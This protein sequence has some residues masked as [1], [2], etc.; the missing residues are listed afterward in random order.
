MET[1][2]RWLIAMDGM[3][4]SGAVIEKTAALSAKE[5]QNPDISLLLI[6]PSEEHTGQ[7][8]ASAELAKMLV[9]EY[10]SPTMRPDTLIKTGSGADLIA[11]TAQNLKC[12]KII[13]GNE[14]SG[15]VQHSLNMKIKEPQKKHNYQDVVALS[16]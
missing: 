11:E 6:I 4:F 9:R 12:S 3:N 10:F 13:L 14:F 1:T 7:A 15:H 16:A 8:Q 5:G 2:E